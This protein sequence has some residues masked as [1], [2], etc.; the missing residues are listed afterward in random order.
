MIVDSS[1]SLDVRVAAIIPALL[2]AFRLSRSGGALRAWGRTM[3]GMVTKH[4]PT[5]EERDQR[6]SVPLEAEEFI[7]GVLAVDPDENSDT[8]DAE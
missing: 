2:D 8:D 4:H 5:P 3:G 6:V 1:G 7:E